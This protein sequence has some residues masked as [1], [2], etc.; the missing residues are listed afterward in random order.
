M[1]QFKIDRLTMEKWFP[2][3][4]AG[5]L[6]AGCNQT[7]DNN[8][9]EE[10]T[11]PALKEVFDGAFVIGSALNR[12]QITGRDDVGVELAA[13]HYN[14]ITPENILKWEQV[15]PE[16]D[17]YN[18]DLPDQFVQF[19]EEN[20][21]FIVGHTLIW[22]N[23]T[24][25]WVFLDEEGNPIDREGLLERMRAHIHTVVGRYKGRIHG[26]DVVNEALNENG[27][28]RE[29]PW[30]EIIG[31]D[32]I[33]KAFE[34]AHEADPDAELY[35]NDYSLENPAKRE[36]AVQLLRNLQER[37]VP[38]TGVGTQG[39]FSLD[40]PSIEDAEA[41]VIAFAD[42]GLDVMVTEFDIDVLPA[43]MDPVGADISIDVELR[44]ELNPWPEA[45]PDSVQQ[46]LAQRY[47]DLFGLY[48]RHRGAIARMTFWGVHDSDSWKNNWPVGGRTNYPLLFDREGNP[49]PAF[50]AVAGVPE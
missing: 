24:P 34:F 11:V 39:H 18:F 6:W 42:L 14:T 12:T 35:Y 3:L 7:P 36:G 4:L 15:H 30:M 29:T 47:A 10:L 21:M 50:H 1:R 9:D 32:Y 38:V 5:L 8:E 44:E 2:F 37:G 40:W 23:Q 26:W 41:T 46:A 33:A 22:H 43:V 48:Y 16:P 27:S 45:L 25:G 49:K 17:E 28:L 31:E 20:G 19:G 13:T